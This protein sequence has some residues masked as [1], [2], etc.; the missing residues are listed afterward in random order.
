[1][2]EDRGDFP[3]ESILAVVRLHVSPPSGRC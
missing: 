2:R 3:H 1:L